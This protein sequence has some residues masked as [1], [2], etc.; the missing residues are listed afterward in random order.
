MMYVVQK[1]IESESWYWWLDMPIHIRTPMHTSYFYALFL[2]CL[3]LRRTTVYLYLAFCFILILILLNSWLEWTDFKA[4]NAEQHLF[5]RTSELFFFVLQ[6]SEMS[7]LCMFVQA[8]DASS[9]SLTAREI[10]TY[11]FSQVE[12]NRWFFFTKRIETTLNKDISSIS[13]ILTPIRSNEVELI[14]F[15]LIGFSRSSVHRKHAVVTAN[16]ASESTRN[17][18]FF[19][20]PNICMDHTNTKKRIH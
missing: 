19:I 3:R 20:Q 18:E 15:N 17:V 9:I 8:N 7:R 12:S 14:K 11:K 1:E 16:I 10:T 6:R 2:F 13:N 5:Q 4:K